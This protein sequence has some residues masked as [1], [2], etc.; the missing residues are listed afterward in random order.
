MK[1]VKEEIFGRVGVVIKFE[2]EA[3]VIK[4]AND[5]H[6]GLAAAVFTQNRAIGTAH[7]LQAGTAWTLDRSLHDATVKPLLHPYLTYKCVT[8]HIL[9]YSERSFQLSDPTVL[10]AFHRRVWLIIM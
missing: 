2:N 5:T 9:W 3:D 6:Y 10:W 8:S 4:Q 1:I 7:K